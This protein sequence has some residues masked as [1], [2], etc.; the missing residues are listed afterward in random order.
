MPFE[1]N[2]ASVWAAELED[3]P[4]AL[5]D[6]LAGLQRA[7]VN[8]E[9]VILRPTAPMSHLG[10]LFVAPIAG[11]AQERAATEAGLRKAESIHA[12]RLVGPDHPGL[13][14]DL[15]RAFASAGL[16]IAGLSAASLAGQAVIYVRFECE[17]DADRAAQLVIGLPG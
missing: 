17:A 10:V 2:R 14:A 3:H 16:N 15:S 9:F 6:M 5:A 11:A 1:I 12:L 4:G 7:G 8:L 13:V